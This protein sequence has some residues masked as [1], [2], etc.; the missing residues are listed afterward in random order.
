MRYMLNNKIYDTEKAQEIVQYIKPI[1]HRSLFFTTYPRY[2]HTLYKTK[3]V[4]FLHI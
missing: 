2:T 4:N 1:E 3:K